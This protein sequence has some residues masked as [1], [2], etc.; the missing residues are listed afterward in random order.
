MK[1]IFN[2]IFLL[3]LAALTCSCRDTFWGENY[4]HH[5]GWARVEDHIVGSKYEI[6]SV[7]DQPVIR[8]QHGQM[9]TVVPF[10]VIP[11]GEHTIVVRLSELRLGKSNNNISTKMK[12][13]VEKDGWY[14]LEESNGVPALVDI[15]DENKTLPKREKEIL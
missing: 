3:L 6:I 12:I 4:D 15:S 7:D 9:V 1:S 2:R 11:E 8:L 14:R 13:S 10:A 5:V